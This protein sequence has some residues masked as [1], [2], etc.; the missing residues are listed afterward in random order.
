MMDFGRLGQIILH[1]DRRMEYGTAWNWL[2]P[3]TSAIG[4]AQ[5]Y[6]VGSDSRTTSTQS[7]YGT[8]PRAASLASHPR[9][10]G[11]PSA[12][13]KNASAWPP[14]PGGNSQCGYIRVRK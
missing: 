8:G 2:T 3:S 5:P 7:R 14:D 4:L 13:E 12:Q 10:Q 9:I 6:V 11:A 1:S